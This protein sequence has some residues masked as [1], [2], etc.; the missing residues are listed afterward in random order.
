M[1][2]TSRKKTA[3]NFL[4]LA[5]VELLNFLLP[6]I[7]MPY[8][9]MVLGV[10]NYGLNSFVQAVMQYFIIV[11]NYGF[12]IS[13][14]QEIS[15]NREDKEKVEQI[16]TNVMTC[17]VLLTLACFGILLLMMTFIPKMNQDPKLY[18]CMFGIVVGSVFLPVW[19]FQGMEEMASIGVL[20]FVSKSIFTVGLFIFVKSPA[21]IYA[22]GILNSLGYLTIG[23]IATLIVRYKYGIH[24]R[25][26]SKTGIISQFKSSWYLFLSTLATSVYN[27][28]NIFVL[29]LVA[30]DTATGYFN[31]ANTLIRVCASVATPIVQT[32]YPKVTQLIQ[33]SKEDSLK[34]IQKIWLVVTVLFTLGCV[35]LLVGSGPVLTWLFQ[36]KFSHSVRLIQIMAFL[37]LMVAWSNVF[38]VMTMTTFGY[39]RELSRIY[40][41]TGLISLVSIIL[42]TVTFKETGTAVNAILIETIVTIS[43]Y[44]FLQK[45]GIQVPKGQLKERVK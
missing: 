1:V 3:T 34:L 11:T 18:L 19:F 24:Y 27:T 16:Y 32:F 21:D 2:K 40:L 33:T 17:K 8:L 38:G 43:M 45:K 5:S 9:I 42:L 14:T 41:V 23:V 25:K 30:G 13:A 15:V 10:K 35:I 12:N 6:L 39:Q 20:N 26:P 4:S 36:D 28:T 29:G 37:P 31:L 22:V 7:T 44:L